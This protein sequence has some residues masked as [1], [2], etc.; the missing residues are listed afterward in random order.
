[1]LKQPNKTDDWTD[2][3][4]VDQQGPKQKLQTICPVFALVCYKCD[5]PF[6]T[7]N[8]LVGLVV[9]ASALRA[10]DPGFKSHLHQD[11]FSV[12]SHTS[13]LKIGTQMATL[14]G[15]WWP[16]VSILWLGEMKSLVCN[17]YLSVALAARTLTS[18]LLPRTLSSQQTTS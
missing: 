15:T 6:L 18:M 13:D 4:Q 9:K 7:M 16:G 1:M 10:E 8:R 3:V 2:A 11:F 14:L 12:L 17:F 5:Q